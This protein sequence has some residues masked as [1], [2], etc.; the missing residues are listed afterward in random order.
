[1]TAKQPTPYSE[2]NS[3]LHDLVTSAQA[4]LGSNFIG[5]YLQGS[6]AVGDFDEH[7]DCDFNMI[8]R[9]PLN[10]AELAALQAMHARIFDQELRWAKHLEGSYFTRESVR[11]FDPDDEPLWY[12]DNGSRQLI[13]HKHDDTLVVRWSLRERGIT[14]AGLDIKTLIDPIEPDA[15]RREVA[16]V[17]ASWA[18]LLFNDPNEMNNVWYQ[19][20]AVLSYCRMLHTV[21]TARVESKPVSA[22]WAKNNLDPRWIGLIDRALAKRPNQYENVHV[23]ADPAELALTLEFIRYM[24]DLRWQMWPEGVPS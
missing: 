18:D 8:I 14:L 23:P 11:R 10:E 7:S 13:Q 5:A 21:Q 12:L 24:L 15:L 22:R 6:F 20:F 17:M 2:L 9:Q 19:M 4:I 3:V 16:D 1:M